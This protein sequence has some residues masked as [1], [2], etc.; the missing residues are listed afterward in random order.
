MTW[1]VL[2][3]VAFIGLSVGLSCLV[4]ASIRAADAREEQADPEEAQW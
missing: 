1:I 4:A 2:G 3:V